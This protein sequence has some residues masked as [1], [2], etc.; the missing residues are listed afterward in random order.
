MGKFAARASSIVLI[1][2]LA[3]VCTAQTAKV[4]KIG[5]LSDAAVTEAV[6][7]TLDPAGY[8]VSLDDGT[9]F[10]LWLRKHV[11]A[12]AKKDAADVL[13]PQLA[14]STLVGVLH[15]RKAAVTIGGR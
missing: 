14:E 8:R 5:P 9:T 1:N 11:P 3:A 13:Y 4:E 2:I 6:R 7:Q 12:Q 10:E 15:F